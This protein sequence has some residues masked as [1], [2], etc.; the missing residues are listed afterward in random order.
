[1][2]LQMNFL[3]TVHALKDYNEIRQHRTSNLLQDKNFWA[4]NKSY[5]LR[6]QQS[7]QLK[8]TAFAFAV[9]SF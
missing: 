5:H 2:I 4:C 6:W 9:F 7:N 1:M 3:K 8:Y